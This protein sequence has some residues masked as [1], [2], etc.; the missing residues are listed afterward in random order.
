MEKEYPR[1]FI[2]DDTKTN[3]ICPDCKNLKRVGELCQ[4]CKDDQIQLEKDQRIQELRLKIQKRLRIIQEIDERNTE[5]EEQILKNKRD[6]KYASA[7]LEHEQM[8]LKKAQLEGKYEYNLISENTRLHTGMSHEGQTMYLE[9]HCTII[10]VDKSYEDVYFGHVTLVITILGEKSRWHYGVKTFNDLPDVL[11]NEFWKPSENKYGPNSHLSK[12]KF[13]GYFENIDENITLSDMMISHFKDCRDDIFKKTGWP[14]NQVWNKDS[15][16]NHEKASDRLIRLKTTSLQ[17]KEMEDK[18]KFSN[19]KLDIEKKERKETKKVIKAEKSVTTSPDA[20]VL[21]SNPKSIGSTSRK[22][23][24]RTNIVSSIPE[25]ILGLRE[26]THQK[27]KKLGSDSDS[28]SDSDSSKK[29]GL[30]TE[31]NPDKPTTQSR[32]ISS[33]SGSGK[34]A[35]PKRKK[36]KKPTTQSIEISSGSGQKP[37]ELEDKKLIQEAIALANAEKD[38]IANSGKDPIA[39]VGKDPNA[40]IKKD[41][42]AKAKNERQNEQI[43][44]DKL[45]ETYKNIRDDVQAEKETLLEK[46]QVTDS[47]Q[48]RLDKIKTYLEHVDNYIRD[49][50]LEHNFETVSFARSVADE[51]EKTLKFL[52]KMKDQRNINK[53]IDTLYIEYCNIK[54]AAIKDHMF[55]YDIPDYQIKTREEYFKRLFLLIT[56]H[57]ILINNIYV[58]INELIKYENTTKSSDIDLHTQKTLTIIN[59]IKIRAESLKVTLYE[60]YYENELE[61]AKRMVDEYLNNREKELRNTDPTS[62]RASELRDLL[63]SNYESFIDN[64]QITISEL[65]SLTVSSEKLQSLIKE[66]EHIKDTVNPEILS[67]IRVS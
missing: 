29:S 9:T 44:S 19:E 43:S 66:F 14:A 36:L 63:I 13:F 23:D 56:E 30:T 7:R 51:R 45:L 4:K 53:I 55:L 42:I 12:V 11:D 5:L 59:E 6:Q 16:F 15:E 39:N 26:L 22:E 52:A 38:R 60:K 18:L 10:R 62:L 49:V 35:K 57:P 28:D 20:N 3:I 54:E 33:G 50:S 8:E 46:I 25:S 27:P 32:E 47:I 40:N 65:K 21:V 1:D 17:L 24:W 2:L 64:H 34:K 61:R 48:F 67:L 58:F 41:R 37:D 31:Q